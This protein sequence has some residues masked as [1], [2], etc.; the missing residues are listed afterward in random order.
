MV[1]RLP[2]GKAAIS[3]R[4]PICRKLGG[5]EQPYLAAAGREDPGL[6]HTGDARVLRRGEC[7]GHTIVAIGEAELVVPGERPTSI[8]VEVALL[9]GQDLVERLVDEG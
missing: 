1:D 8:G 5:P 7:L 9:L 6:G 2:D 3:G 4:V